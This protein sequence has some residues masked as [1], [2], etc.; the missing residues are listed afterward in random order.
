MGAKRAAAHARLEDCRSPCLPGNDL[1]VVLGVPIGLSGES[2]SWQHDLPVCEASSPCTYADLRKGATRGPSRESRYP[3]SV[4]LQV[5][6]CRVVGYLCPTLWHD[7]D[8]ACFGTEC[9]EGHG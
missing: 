7:Q 2:A 6:R 4:P 3:E 8:A 9:N 1:P 5:Q